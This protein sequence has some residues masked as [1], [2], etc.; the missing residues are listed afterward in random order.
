[1]LDILKEYDEGIISIN[2][3][4]DSRYPGRGIYKILSRS[5]K[6]ALPLN[7]YGDGMKKAILLMSAVLK[8]QN[9]I[10]LLDEF[11]TPSFIDWEIPNSLLLFFTTFISLFFKLSIILSYLVTNIISST[12]SLLFFKSISLSTVCKYIGLLS[13]SYNNL[14]PLNRLLFPDAKTIILSFNVIF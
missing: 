14:F 11:E 9:G 10:L 7:V 4:N 3:D 5:C 6:E 8:A 12:F 13:I 1:M 2:Y